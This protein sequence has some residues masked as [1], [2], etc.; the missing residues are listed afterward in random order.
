MMW[1][2]VFIVFLAT[3]K[4]IPNWVFVAVFLIAS[5]VQGYDFYVDYKVNQMN[6]QNLTRYIDNVNRLFEKF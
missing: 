4:I 1:V 2:V 5:I 6:Q 3:P